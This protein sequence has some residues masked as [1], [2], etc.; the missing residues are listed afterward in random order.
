M[1]LSISYDVFCKTIQIGE[2]LFNLC[3]SDY[4]DAYEHSSKYFTGISEHFID[5]FQNHSDC[6][7]GT[8]EYDLLRYFLIK[9]IEHRIAYV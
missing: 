9:A 5:Y 1:Q 4:R 6:R 8:Y 7:P 2:Q 3:Y